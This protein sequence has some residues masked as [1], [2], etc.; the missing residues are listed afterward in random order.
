MLGFAQ[1]ISAETQQTSFQSGSRNKSVHLST[2]THTCRN[3]QWFQW[4]PLS[5]LAAVLGWI[6][7]PCPKPGV[8]LPA[9]PPSF[10][11]NHGSICCNAGPS[12]SHLTT[13]WG[14]RE[15]PWDVPKTTRHSVYFQ[16]LS[17]ENSLCYSLSA[18]NKSKIPPSKMDLPYKKYCNMK[19]ISQANS[20]C[21][22]R[23]QPKA[24]MK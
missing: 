13:T 5:N 10:Q 24:Q 1:A 16:L 3:S 11:I 12:H 22:R 4:C 6:G 17:L 14:D 2:L 7:W 23:K 9:Q 19:E 21:S 18:G 8:T 15:A 20:L